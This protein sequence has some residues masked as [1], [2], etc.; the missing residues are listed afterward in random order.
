MDH[1]VREN[2]TVP[3]FIVEAHFVSIEQRPDE[4]VNRPLKRSSVLEGSPRWHQPGRALL[5]SGGRLQVESRMTRLD[6][7]RDWRIEDEAIP[8]LGSDC[9]L[10]LR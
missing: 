4:R 9:G 2:G 5:L 10:Q 3:K 6:K 1:V 8:A 7:R